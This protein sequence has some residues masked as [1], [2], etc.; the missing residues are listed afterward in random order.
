M[1]WGILPRLRSVLAGLY[2]I[3]KVIL[4]LQIRM[5]KPAVRLPAQPVPVFKSQA[6]RLKFQQLLASGQIP[7]QTFDLYEKN[8]QRLT[9]PARVDNSNKVRTK[10]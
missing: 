4:N 1:E 7:K 8:S 10:K 5:A 3:K 6:Q 9:L 2:K